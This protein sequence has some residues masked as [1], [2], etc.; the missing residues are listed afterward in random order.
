MRGDLA[1]L[2]YTALVFDFAGFGESRG[3][4][5]QAEIPSRKIADIAAAVS[6]LRSFAFVDPDR[7][8]CLAICASA[9]YVLRAVADGVP[10]KILRQRRGLVSRSGLRRAVLWR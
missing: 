2:G 9:Q 5:R 10:L 3:D 8:G 1:E 7:I 6:L 4:P